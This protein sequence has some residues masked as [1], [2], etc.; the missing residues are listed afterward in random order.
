MTGCRPQSLSSSEKWRLLIGWDGQARNVQLQGSESSDCDCITELIFDCFPRQRQF[1]TQGLSSLTMLSS[2]ALAM[3]PSMLRIQPA[4]QVL[5]MR[6]TQ[7]MFNQTRGLRTTAKMMKP[8]PV[9]CLNPSCCSLTS[10][11]HLYRGRSTAVCL[12]D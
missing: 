10:A 1:N 8:V 2:R 11:N 9:R 7:H 6:P 4:A 3:A 12:P 5:K